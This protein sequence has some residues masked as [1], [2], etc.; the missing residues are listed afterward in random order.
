MVLESC[1]ECN[2]CSGIV[3]GIED[4]D[5]EIVELKERSK[6]IIGRNTFWI[7]IGLLFSTLAGLFGY[8]I[9]AKE[10]ANAAVTAVA[11]LTQKAEFILESQRRIEKQIERHMDLSGGR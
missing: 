4:H 2:A 3:K 8:M 7:I 1:K 5:R 11:V 10:M 9:V 6:S